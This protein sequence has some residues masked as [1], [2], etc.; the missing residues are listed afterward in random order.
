MES[1]RR[2][3]H[4]DE[5]RRVGRRVERIS[6]ATREMGKATAGSDGLHHAAHSRV[7]RSMAHAPSPP[8]TPPSPALTV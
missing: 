7:P 6:Q 2:I 5:G 8:P 4:V 1:T 3:D